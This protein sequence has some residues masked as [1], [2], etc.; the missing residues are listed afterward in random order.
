MS[1]RYFVNVH[2]LGESERR[3][4]ERLMDAMGKL[5][6]DSPEWVASIRRLTELR[7]LTTP[8]ALLLVRAVSGDLNAEQTKEAESYG[9]YGHFL[10][11]RAEIKGL[12]KHEQTSKA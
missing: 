9:I 4:A 1:E 10:Q 11:L 7:I 12:G 5:E 2:E 8:V 6:L 3:E